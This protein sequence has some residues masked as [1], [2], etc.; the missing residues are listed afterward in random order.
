MESRIFIYQLTE[1]VSNSA[2]FVDYIL[3]GENKIDIKISCEV[4]KCEIN[5]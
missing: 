3:H 4:N 5:K 2:N 1:R